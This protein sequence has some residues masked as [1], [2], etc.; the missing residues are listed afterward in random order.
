[1]LRFVSWMKFQ[2]AQGRNVFIRP[3]AIISI[4]GN[5]IVFC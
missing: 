3:M 2:N 1:L 5:A 4:D